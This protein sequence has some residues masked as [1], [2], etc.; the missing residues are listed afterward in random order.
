MDDASS[1][2]ELGAQPE[3]IS[4]Q[5][6]AADPPDA[7]EPQGVKDPDRPKMLGKR[8]AQT[9]LTGSILGVVLALAVHYLITQTVEDSTRFNS[10]SW[11][12]AAVGG[13]T[14]GGACTLFIYGAATDRSDLDGPT[15]HGRA[16]VSEQG[17]WRR[18]LER[19][20]RRNR[21]G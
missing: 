19:R 4:S 9:V 11:A 3:P 18:T 12:F 20:R 21:R 6:L 15:P 1:A 2:P 17:E 7:G 8:F 16:D 5:N 13:F 14:V 10:W